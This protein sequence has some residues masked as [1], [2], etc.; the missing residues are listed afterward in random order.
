MV[1]EKVAE[2]LQERFGA[3]VRSVVFFRGEGTALIDV[4]QIVAVGTHCR[5]DLGFRFLSDLTAVDWQ[6]RDP[7]FDVVY[8]I[9]NLTDWTRFRLKVQINEGDRVETVSTVWGAA[10][11]AEREAFDL[12]GIEFA[13]HPD[14]RRLL[15]PEGWIGYPLRKDYP[16]SQI[17][18][19]RSKAEKT[20]E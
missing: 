6:D 5:D 2:A 20:L 1:P 3:A 10:N 13:G 8:H 7:R 11:W 12:F 14:L 9:T 16:Q 19:P 4:G 15:L 17:T 18:L